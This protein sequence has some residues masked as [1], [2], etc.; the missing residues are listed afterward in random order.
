MGIN[1]QD[2]PHNEDAGNENEILSK[3]RAS[4]TSTDNISGKNMEHIMAFP[5]VDIVYTWVNGSDPRQ[6]EG[7]SFTLYPVF[8]PLSTLF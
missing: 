2:H 8:W 7:M 5:P 6:I 4:R 3:L 1:I